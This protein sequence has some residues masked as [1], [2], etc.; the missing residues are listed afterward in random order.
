MLTLAF[1]SWG[2]ADARKEAWGPF[3]R[4]WQLEHCSMHVV[5]EN[6][7]PVLAYAKAWSPSLPGRVEADVVLV[8]D[9]DAERSRRWTSP[10]RSCCWRARAA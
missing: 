10:A 6:P 3:G 4:A 9:L 1:A 7:W 5:G 8:A 2:L